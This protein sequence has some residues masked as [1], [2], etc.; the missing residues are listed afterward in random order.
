MTRHVQQLIVCLWCVLALIVLGV[1]DAVAQQ[2]G[3]VAA[4]GFEEGAGATT[5]DA[6]GN[7]QLGM[8]SGAAWSTSGRYGRALQFDGLNDVVTVLGT[9]RLDLRTGM[10]IEAWVLPVRSGFAD[11]VIAKDAPG[12]AAYAMESGINDNRPEARIRLLG[13]SERRIRNG[14][15]PQNAWSHVAATYDGATLRLYLNG[16]LT[17]QRAAAGTLLSST[18]AL[19]IGADFAVQQFFAGRID[20]VRI[21]ARAISAAE[22]QADMAT[23]VVPP[24]PDTVPPSVAIL[25]PTAG[26]TVSDVVGISASASDNE[27]V[28]SVR[29]LVDGEPIGPEHTIAPYASSWNSTTVSNGLHTV[30]AVAVDAAGN[31]AT[32]APV[33][34]G[35]LNDL[36]P[37]V[38]NLVIAAAG[39]TASGT[40][41]LAATAMD[42]VGVAGVEFRL[43]G[44]S[45]GEDTEAPY[46]VSWDT[47][48]TTNGD[49]IVIAVARDAS[50][51][52]ATSQAVTVTVL[53][54]ANAPTASILAPAPGATVSGSVNVIAAATDDVGVA[55]V[56]FLLDGAKLGAEDTTA[57]YETIWDTSLVADG[58]HALSAIARDATGKITTATAVAV[59]VGNH[60]A[61][62]VAGD[63][64]ATVAEDSEA[65]AIDVLAND[66][67]PDED[68]QTITAVTQAAN[69]SVAIMAG[70]TTLTYTP[71]ANFF[72]TDSFSYTVSDGNGQSDSATVS[73]TVT[74]VNDPPTAVDDAFTIPEDAESPLL[75][76]VVTDNDTY[77]P[78]PREDLWVI[79]VTQPVHGTLGIGGETGVPDYRAPANFCGTDSLSYTV[80]DRKGG[81]A[82][83]NVTITV[84]CVNDLIKAV[85]DNFTI[86]E[87]STNAVLDILAN[88][89]PA[90][91][92]TALRV[93]GCFTETGAAGMDGI[94]TV[95]ADRSHILYT[96]NRNF[97][98]VAS[99]SCVIEDDFQKGANAPYATVTVRV[100]PVN[101]APV[102]ANDAAST[103][104]D[105]SVSSNVLS[106]DTDV[107]EATALTARLVGAPSA[108][109]GTVVLNA[110][111]TFTFTPAASFA[112]AATFTYVANDGEA[113]SNV[114]VATI[115]V[116]EVNDAPTAVNDLATTAEDASIDIAVLDNDS[117]ADGD[118]IA[119]SSVGTPAHGIAS[120]NPNGSVKY[121]PNADYFGSDI[122]TYTIGDGGGG[123]ATA[124]VSV[125][126][127]AVNDAPAVNV[128]APAAGRTVSGSIAVSASA[129]DDTGIASVA[130]LLDGASLGEDETAPYEI[131]WDTSGATNGDHVLTAI[132]RDVSGESTTS[133]SVAVTVSNDAAAPAVSLT[134][135]AAAST[136]SGTVAVTASA[137]DDIGVEGVQFL[138]DGVNLGAEDTTAP[139]EVSWDTTGASNGDYALTAIARDASGKSSTSAA[140]S[141]KVSNDA[142]APAVTITAPAAGTVSGS[143]AVTASASDD[144]GV[145]GVQF[146]LDGAKLG[147]EDMTTPYEASW[148]TTSASNGDHAVTAIARDASG[149]T[150]TS[151][152]VTVTVAN[153]S[154]APAV[155]L[156]AP[157]TGST[158]SGT[159]TVSA[160]ATDDIAV[161]G[162]QFLLDGANLGAEDTAAPYST[163]W[164]TTSL[165]NGTHTL[166]A[167]ARDAS[168]KRTTSAEVRVTVA[169][170]GAAPT[171]T[172]TAPGAG[173]SVSG[174]IAVS[175]SADDDI[176]VVGVQF[177]LDGSNLG[178]ED[179]TAPYST[180]WATAT[181]AN[182][183]HTLTAV[184][185]DASGKRTTSSNVNV[186]VSNETAAPT[187]SITAPAPGSTVSGSIAVIAAAS[188][189]IGVVGVQFLV[190]GVNL[191]AEDSTVP[192]TTTWTTGTAS[193][194]THTL[195]AIARDASGKRTTSAGVTVTVANDNTAP[196]VG[197]TAPIGGSTVSSSIVVTASATDDI[198]VVGV[199][200]LLDGSPLGP[201]DTSAPYDASWDTTTVA[202]GAHLLSATARDASGKRSTSAAVTVNV[203]NVA[204]PNDPS[205]I[206]QWAGPFDWPLVTVHM[207][208]MHTGDVL[209]WD[210]QD[211]GGVSA[212]IWNPTTN[213][214]SAAP[215]GFTNLFCAS[216]AQ[217][218]DGRIL[219]AGGHGPT[220]LGSRDANVYDPVTRQWTALP[221]M[222][223]ARWYP[224]ATTLPDGRVLVVGGAINCFTCIAEVPEIYDPVANTWTEISTARINLPLYPYDIVL[225]DGR[226]ANVGANEGITVTRTLDLQTNTW[227][228]VD[229]VAVDGG[230]AAMYRPG[231]ILKSGSWSR[232]TDLPN[233]PASDTAYVI[234]MNE[235]SP[236]WRQVESMAFPRAHHVL[237]LLPDGNVLATG[238]QEM[239]DGITISEAVLDAEIWSPESE[240]WAPAGRMQTPRLYHG[241][242]LLLPD[243]RVLVS[244]GGR[245]G[246]ARDFLN[247]EIYSPPYLFKGSRPRI[248]ATPERIDFAEEF[249]VATPDAA[250]I[251][252]V[253]LLRPGSVTHTFNTEQRYLELAFRQNGAGL[254][255]TA[256]ANAN[257]APPGYYMLFLVNGTGVPSVASFVRLPSPAEDLQAPSAPSSLVAVAG[258]GTA[259]LQWTAA[260]DNTGVALYNVHRSTSPGTVPTAA[261]RIAQTPSLG[262]FDTGLAAGSYFYVVTA[263]D[264]VG[265]VGAPSNEVA[266]TVAADTVAPTV[267]IT[268][269]AEGEV[270]LNI[271]T[272]SASAADNVGVA[273]VQFVLD[274][275]NIGAEDVV[276]PFSMPWNT[277]G[278]PNGTHVLTAVARDG[279]GH[280]TQS[281]PV[282]VTVSNN[283]TAPAGLMAAYNFD[284]GTGSVLND[285]SGSGNPGTVSGATWSASGHTGSALNFDGVNDWVT[286]ADSPDL[287]L[288]GAMTLEAWIYPTVHADWRSAIL[289]ETPGGLAYALYSSDDGSRPA[290][291][292]N[293]GAGDVAAT[294][295]ASLP[296]NTWSHVAV[297]YD[298]ASLRLYIN[299]NAV[300]STG[301]SG[302]IVRSASPLR[303]G[304]NSVWGEFFA[305]RLDDVRIYNRALGT[306]EIQVDMATPVP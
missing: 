266:V 256:P 243:G 146:L 66:T 114:G 177:L 129:T 51:K 79:D 91:T 207:S 302:S 82:T 222:A 120:A 5:S 254:T 237:T 60:A 185:R 52:S 77:A 156:T 25:Q 6:S 267:A 283:G 167:V 204:D 169:N 94:V 106:N 147:L 187:V 16:T 260:T 208:L 43:D 9:P 192:F 195:S 171:I 12:G 78:D 24:V 280:T 152:A 142:T 155:S 10:T 194:G 63:D 226:V 196:V 273:G 48:T 228:V 176:G 143:L 44:L 89:I 127:T 135:P 34:F 199:Q 86:L 99:F 96:P 213:Q 175:A 130:F 131:S 298:G 299:G 3:P 45:L 64:T 201:E 276:A 235:T 68:T 258:T 119:L 211:D 36:T 281:V 123:S 125:T 188:D 27:A 238:G 19:R 7:G 221:R 285:R 56:Q 76:Y 180:T 32:S 240:T 128:T 98:G 249:Q 203:S 50:G 149:K 304:G 18:G 102:A 179:T 141:V 55:G 209:A 261:N 198:G 227:S 172:I 105:T 182:G 225:P 144:I 58:S 193:N 217:L 59:T 242:A 244:G 184:A 33:T 37:P 262:H 23:P 277:N 41:Q 274:G 268:S 269:P 85:D 245:L 118:T 11:P 108:D 22:I 259:T 263:Q 224:T 241:N 255:V 178:A 305:G 170:D 84:T 174:S 297:T 271:V 231:K 230:S 287:A 250:A 247:A 162:V 81:T 253:V 279:A 133:S 17:A 252:S 21:Y 161:A 165:S 2:S 126:V 270:V 83:A 154:T 220:N 28:A 157:G 300:G 140:V 150:T 290:A 234:D 46:E 173:S 31:S 111:G 39:G 42:D 160:S 292:V 69:G 272:V 67:D 113:D 100:T 139:Y 239:T 215:N 303:L 54:D 8:L 4:Y 236:Q 251:T 210:G 103:A 257:F 93:G 212:T 47:T 71:K 1:S 306:A 291:Y 190:D 278:V 248:E 112:G 13:Q 20:E 109:H 200:F 88:D 115:T 57:P 136:L 168:G 205:R 265:N 138:L 117:D 284:E 53:N 124:T 166:S 62:P 246:G 223:F 14:S 74:N 296:L 72:G 191:G 97:A 151:A 301:M 163:I 15:I 216:H 92:G 206:G 132:A 218:A 121:T 158:V 80:S 293:A 189:D 29:I 65:N 101:D 153:D 90:D 148:D 73:I 134:A 164:N 197:I 159:V 87:D 181:A 49:H 282:T 137:S 288:G 95:A 286:V 219:V 183:T 70:G 38:V 186:T 295:S 264:V 26:T 116:T 232:N 294:G 202:N 110:N 104:E 233:A 289:K 145:I 122:F 30:T 229:P 107:D 214:F 35:V 61:A 40:I 275:V 75:L